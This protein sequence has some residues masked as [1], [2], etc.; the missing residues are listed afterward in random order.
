MI[1]HSILTIWPYVFSYVHILQNSYT[2]E[3]QFF[4]FTNI[5]V[6]RRK[7]KFTRSATWFLASWPLK[8]ELTITQAGSGSRRRIFQSLHWQC[9][10]ALMYLMVLPLNA[11]NS[12][13]LYEIWMLRCY[14]LSF[15][16][17]RMAYAS[18][19][20]LIFCK[21]LGKFYPTASRAY[22]GC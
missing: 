4:G 12:W 18:T 20:K 2:F 6:C 17:D 7:S 22:S 11:D 14:K 19:W 9:S 8:V 10:Y 13:L 5:L 15:V 16:A 1:K 21:W 3:C